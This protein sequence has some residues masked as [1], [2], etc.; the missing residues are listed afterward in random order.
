MLMNRLPPGWGDQPSS[1][2]VALAILVEADGIP[3][4]RFRRSRAEGGW[5][6]IA[7]GRGASYP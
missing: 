2:E 7:F 5:V 3:N 4:R 1:A 6:A